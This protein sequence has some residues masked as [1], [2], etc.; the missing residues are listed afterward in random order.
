M[1]KELIKKR[2]ET[3]LPTYNEHA[4]IQ[5]LMAQKIISMLNKKNYPEILE[6]G[7]GTGL[8]TKLIT[9]NLKFQ[10]FTATDIVDKCEEYIKK[11]DTNI[12]FESNAAEILLTDIKTY[13]LIISN[14]VFQWLPDVENIIP[15]LVNKLKPGGTLFFSTFGEKNFEEIFNV[16]GKTLKYKTL[17][18]WCKILK[19]FNYT[20]ETEI[21]ILNFASPIDVLKHLKYTGVN[22]LENLSWTKADMFKF[23]R[24]YNNYCS[25]LPTLTYNPIY[26]KIENILK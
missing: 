24:E 1:N 3:S 12:N 25:Q 26:I 13:D 5:K 11:I 6:I 10:S 20:M 9:E 22:S 7:C 4:V 18:E 15:E 2:F 16:C 8:L 14:A 23:E 19:N 21:K 17:E